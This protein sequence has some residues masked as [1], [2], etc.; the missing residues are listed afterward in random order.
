MS[1]YIASSELIVDEVFDRKEQFPIIFGVLALFLAAGSFTNARIVE[2][3]GVFRMIRAAAIALVGAAALMAIIALVFAGEPP[4]LLFGL[5]IALLLPVVAILM[6]NSNTA[7][8]LPLPHVAGTAAALLGTVSTAGGS[9]L[10]SI[11]DARFDGTVAPFA[12][13]VLVYAHH[14]GGRDLR[15]RPAP[16]APPRARRAWAPAPRRGLTA[17]ATASGWDA[18]LPLT[19]APG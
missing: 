2:R 17:A 15:A 9:L 8:M 18:A 3:I 6:P 4:L 14:R 12:H 10:G 16:G 11:L 7:A 1:A 5:S 13:G 19:A